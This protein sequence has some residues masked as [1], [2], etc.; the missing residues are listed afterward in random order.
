VGPSDFDTTHLFSALWCIRSTVSGGGQAIG[1]GMN[2]AMNELIGGWQV[3]GDSYGPTPALRSAPILAHF[4]SASCSIGPA[5]SYWLSV[6]SFN[7]HS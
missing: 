6:W 7:P 1:R 2:K 5:V 3:F 4:R